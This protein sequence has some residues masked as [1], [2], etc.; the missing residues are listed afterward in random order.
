[1]AKSFLEKYGKDIP[2]GVI[3]G[4]VATI[5][6]GL[7]L[8]FLFQQGFFA[9]KTEIEVELSFPLQNQLS[10]SF[11]N[12]ADYAAKDFR[13]Y[14]D[15][16]DYDSRA[17][18]TFSPENT[19]CDV[20]PYSSGHGFQVHCDYIPP[21]SPLIFYVSVSPSFPVIEKNGFNVVYWS[22]TTPITKLNCKLDGSCEKIE[23]TPPNTWIQTSD[24]NQNINLWVNGQPINTTYSASVERTTR[25]E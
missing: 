25:P 18:P 24:D 12:K 6:G 10:L 8:A 2:T 19:L 22:E 4:L 21:K 16:L 11:S 7:I 5:V 3:S 1:M 14:V 13:M 23:L 15:W 17:I 20:A 9:P